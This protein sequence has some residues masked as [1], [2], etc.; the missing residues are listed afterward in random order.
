MEKSESTAKFIAGPTRLNP[1]PMLPRQV[2]AVE[3]VVI[4]S[5][6]LM[7]MSRMPTKSVAIYIKIKFV[8]LITTSLESSLPLILTGTI[9]LG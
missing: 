5:S 7:P 4:K 3:T 8:I 9:L 1:G 6:P 2:A